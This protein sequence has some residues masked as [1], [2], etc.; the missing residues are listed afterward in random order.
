VDVVGRAFAAPIAVVNQRNLRPFR[1]A[2][3]GDLVV[4]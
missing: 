4:T 3:A 2:I 1:M